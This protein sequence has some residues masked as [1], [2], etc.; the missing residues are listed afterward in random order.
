MFVVHQFSSELIKSRIHGLNSFMKQVTTLPD[1][2]NWWVELYPFTSLTHSITHRCH[3][4]IQFRANW[5][6]YRAPAKS[7]QKLDNRASQ[8]WWFDLSVLLSLMWL[9][10][11]WG[12][13]RVVDFFPIYVT[14]SASLANRIIVYEMWTI[15]SFLL[16]FFLL[17]AT[18]DAS[19]HFSSCSWLLIW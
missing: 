10:R 3:N 12:K 4:T 1:I 18:W 16:R 11:L 19:F 6:E 8:H 9:V 5:N 15:Y 14:T 17:T 2:E 13:N 7:V